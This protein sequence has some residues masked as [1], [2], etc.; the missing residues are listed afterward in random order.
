MEC[1]RTFRRLYVVCD[2]Q[3]KGVGRKDRGKGEEEGKQ[4]YNA[5]ITR[6][7]ASLTSN[8]SATAPPAASC[9][10]AGAGCARGLPL[11][12]CVCVCLRDK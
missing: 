5:R 4:G 9:L 6:R 10:S 11:C 2:A 7:A 1:A 3:E 8:G 12:V